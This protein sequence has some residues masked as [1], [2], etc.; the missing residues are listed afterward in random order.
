MIRDLKHN[1]YFFGFDDW[2]VGTPIAPVPE[3]AT[4]ALMGIGLAGISYR[5][6][7][8]RSGASAGSATTR[9]PCRAIFSG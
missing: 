2:T 4:L 6:A 3:P 5:M 9:P 1:E 8:A 7:G